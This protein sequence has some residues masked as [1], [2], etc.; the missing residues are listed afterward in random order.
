MSERIEVLLVDDDD[1]DA[2]LTRELLSE[3][4]EARFSVERASDARSALT[5]LCANRHDVCLL[6]YRLGRDTGLDVL[7]E[8]QARGSDVPVIMLTGTGDRSVDLAAM[9]EGAAEYLEKGTIDARVLERA[10]RYAMARKGFERELAAKKERLERL[11]AEKNQLLGMA[12]HDLRNPLGVVYGYASLL[13]SG[14]DTYSTAEIREMVEIIARSSAFMRGLIDDLLDLA[15]IEAG[16]LRLTVRPTDPLELAQKNVALNKILAAGKSIDIQL[17]ADEGLPLVDADAERFDQVLNN[18][19]SNAT[20]YSPPGAPV[21]VRVR[22]DGADV[23]FDVVDRGRGISPEFLATLFTPFAKE[24]T[25]GTAGEKST[26]LGLAIVK[27]IV[28][29]HGGRLAVKSAPGEG[30]T[31]SVW[32][33]ARASRHGDAA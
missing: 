5:A 23:R 4:T 19:L 11:D 17:E 28:D 21:R 27:R 29:A 31:F 10:I 12:A 15:S 33:P 30:S 24:G 25:S 22:A 1:E 2:L 18:L 20:K 7:R 9:K 3:A 13:L 32:L 16:T 26:G 6:D 8:A 14:L